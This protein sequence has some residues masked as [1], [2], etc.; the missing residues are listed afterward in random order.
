MQNQSF[1]V[2]ENIQL[3]NPFLL[4]FVGLQLIH[5]AQPC[6]L[7]TQRQNLHFRELTAILVAQV[8][9]TKISEKTKEILTSDL[10]S[11]HGRR[12]G[13]DAKQ[14]NENKLHLSDPEWPLLRELRTD[15]EFPSR[16]VALGSVPGCCFHFGWGYQQSSW[17]VSKISRTRGNGW[18]TTGRVRQT[19][20]GKRWTDWIES[21]VFNTSPT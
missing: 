20:P 18:K 8:S 17:A 4:S 10:F 5:P 1:Q 14:I 15:Q 16:R 19:S 2:R 3:Q 7:T 11:I 12:E 9:W 21:T 6:K 13:D